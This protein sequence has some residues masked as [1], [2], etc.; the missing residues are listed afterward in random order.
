MTLSSRTT[1]ARGALSTAS[2]SSVCFAR[3]SWTMPIS[4]LATST[5]P[6]VASWISPTARMTTSIAPRMALKRVRMLARRISVYVRLVRSPA[7]FVSR[8]STRSRTSASVRPWSGV[9]KA[10]PGAVTPGR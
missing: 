7:S 3:I 1:R 10:G 9:S 5:I 8:R 2:R 6:N 4:A